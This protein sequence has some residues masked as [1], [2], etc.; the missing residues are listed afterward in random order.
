MV[1]SKRILSRNDIKRKEEI[2]KE[3]VV[4][5]IPISLL[6]I[7]WTRVI[8]Y[9]LLEGFYVEKIIVRFKDEYGSGEKTYLSPNIVKAKELLKSKEVFNIVEVSFLKFP[10][11]ERIIFRLDEVICKNV[12]PLTYENIKNLTSAFF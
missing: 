12:N 2:E 6:F 7:D 3:E 1:K 11:N 8:E 4:K 10:E 5:H 9:L